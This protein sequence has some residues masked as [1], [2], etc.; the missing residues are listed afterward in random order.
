M[1]EPTPQDRMARM[2]TGYWVSQAIYAA[3][4]LGLADR[5]AEGPRIAD[6]LAQATGTH[7]RSLYRLPLTCSSSRSR[8]KKRDG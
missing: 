5:L 7:A 1:P 3:A 2:I 8:R 4:R 6:E